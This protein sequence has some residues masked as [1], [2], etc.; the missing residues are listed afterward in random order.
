M[1]DFKIS[2]NQNT[3]KPHSLRCFTST[4]RIIFFSFLFKWQFHHSCSCTFSAFDKLS[5]PLARTHSRLR[6]PPYWKL[7][8]TFSTPIPYR[9]RRVKS[10]G[11]LFLSEELGRVRTFSFPVGFFPPSC[12][13]A[14]LPYFILSGTTRNMSRKTV[15][16]VQ[17]SW[18]YLHCPGTLKPAQAGCRTVGE[19]RRNG[20][21]E[22]HLVGTFWVANLWMESCGWKASLRRS[23]LAMVA[24]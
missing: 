5:A 23:S 10:L 21:E 6:Y 24:G 2:L 14:G 15:W 20:G 7:W 16:K 18:S 12:R 4:N 17:S 11:A 13:H 1:V 3:H 19:A 9:Q 22:K 8:R